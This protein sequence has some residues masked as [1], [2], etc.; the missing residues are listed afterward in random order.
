MFF[1]ILNVQHNLKV[2]A[3]ISGQYFF[4][5]DEFLGLANANML[6]FLNSCNHSNAIF[7]FYRQA[8]IDKQAVRA[9]R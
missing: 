2:I 7:A 3:K 4:L 1:C 8:V 9:Y 5:T 6:E